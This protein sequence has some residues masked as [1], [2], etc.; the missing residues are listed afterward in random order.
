[1]SDQDIP[2]NVHPS[3]STRSKS[4]DLFSSSSI[5][6]STSSSSHGSAKSAVSECLGAWLNY[7]QVRVDWNGT[8]RSIR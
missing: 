7:L 8:E 3:I 4:G 5:S 6:P 2:N 1:M